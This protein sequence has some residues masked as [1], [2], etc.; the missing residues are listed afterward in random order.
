M[1]MHTQH[2][3]IDRI[4]GPAAGASA[5]GLA[6]AAQ[7]H[8][9]LLIGGIV[10][11]SYHLSAHFFSP[12]L[13]LAHSAIHRHWG[14]LRWIW[15]PYARVVP[16]RSRWSH[17]PGASL[18]KLGYVLTPL[19]G[20]CAILS[21]E[22]LIRA[23]FELIAHAALTLAFIGGMAGADAVHCL[24]DYFFVCVEEDEMPR[25]RLFR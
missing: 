16:H 25:L 20:L 11:A 18:L 4:A 6:F 22:L 17:T 15:A 21:P 8:R 24:A 12:D 10:L 13:D 2:V 3:R 14:P 19:I 7:D 9:A 5:F 1:P 23:M